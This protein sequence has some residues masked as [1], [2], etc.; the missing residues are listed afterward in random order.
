MPGLTIPGLQLVSLA[1][2]DQRRLQYWLEKASHI[3]VIDPDQ[4]NPFS[5]GLLNLLGTSQALVHSVQSISIGHEKFYDASAIA[6]SLQER[7]RAMTAVQKELKEAD[8]ATLRGALLSVLLLGLSTAWL[9][10]HTQDEFGEEHLHG[11]RSILDILLT[12]AG[13]TE[14]PIVRAGVAIYLYWDQSTAFLP[15]FHKH[16]L[17]NNTNLW[18]CVK[19]MRCDYDPVVGYSIEVLYILADLGHYCRNVI[20]GTPH[21][22]L[23]EMIFEE[24][25]LGLE[26]L[27][28]DPTTH[29]VDEAFRKHG[30]I[31]LYRT[32]LTN[33][34]S[35]TV[36]DIEDGSFG[37]EASIQQFAREILQML[38]AIP[39]SSR[40]HPL[41][42]Q[43]LFTAATEVSDNTSRDHVRDRFRKLFAMTRVYAYLQA[44]EILDELWDLHDEGVHMFWMTHMLRKQHICALC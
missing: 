22:N 42:A 25:L 35:E 5:F 21:D 33:R 2:V 20:V 6:E 26:F 32:M 36:M 41:L 11:A 13:A 16:V 10:Y 8:H 39:E 34:S 37:R 1:N 19:S 7:C 43:P 24:Q 17:F 44:I 27:N 15:Q 23:A 31:M 14:D 30:L 38:E 9:L 12:K 28:T 3:M 29:L 18:Q 4:S 40:Y